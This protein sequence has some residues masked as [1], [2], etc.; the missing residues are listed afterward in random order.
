M[1][2]FYKNNFLLIIKNEISKIDTITYKIIIN[3]ISYINIFD[4]HENLDITK[5]IQLRLIKKSF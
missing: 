1:H 4:E 2:I 3:I 5:N